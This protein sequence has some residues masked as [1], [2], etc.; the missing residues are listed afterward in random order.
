MP[1]WSAATIAWL[2]MIAREPS[3]GAP[4]ASGRAATTAGSGA[5]RNLIVRGAAMWRL[6]LPRAP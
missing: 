2:K 6:L 4:G 3:I 1:T 5:V